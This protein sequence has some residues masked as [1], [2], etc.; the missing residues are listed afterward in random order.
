VALTSAEKQKAMRERKAHGG[1]FRIREFWCH[2]D[3]EPQLRAL[4]KRL[5]EDRLKMTPN[6]N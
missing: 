2:P 6:A 5:R 1:I 4:E 3:D